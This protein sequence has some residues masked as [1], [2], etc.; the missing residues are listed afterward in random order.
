MIHINSKA[1]AERRKLWSDITRATYPPKIIF[2][3]GKVWN[4][5]TKNS[6]VGRLPTTQKT[7][8][9]L[10][11]SQNTL[12]VLHAEKLVSLVTDHFW[13]GPADK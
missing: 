9:I 8:I 10:I 2:Y 11:G 12:L 5:Q 6:G 3:L 7:G 4:K 13:Y 1:K